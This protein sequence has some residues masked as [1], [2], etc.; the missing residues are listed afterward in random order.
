MHFY[1]HFNMHFSK[2]SEEKIEDSDLEYQS[3]EKDSTKKTQKESKNKNAKKDKE[4]SDHDEEEVKSNYKK[5]G[6]LLKK[7]DKGTKNLEMESLA[8]IYNIKDEKHPFKHLDGV[9]DSVSIEDL[10]DFERKNVIYFL[11]VKLKN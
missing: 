8:I 6:D 9:P 5:R 11:N 1:T 10:V 4:E 3:K 7:T 2:K